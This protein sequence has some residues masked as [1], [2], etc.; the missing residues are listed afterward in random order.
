[1]AGSL[2]GE[3]VWGQAGSNNANFT[4]PPMNSVLSKLIDHVHPRGLPESSI[5][6]DL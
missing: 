3:D 2:K 6:T 4:F 1:M 5:F